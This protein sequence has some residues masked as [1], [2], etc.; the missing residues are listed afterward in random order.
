MKTK[1]LARLLRSDK[2]IPA[3]VRIEA[4]QRLEYLQHELDSLKDR[5]L[6]LKKQVKEKQ[7]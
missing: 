7:E 4:A 1:S 3:L 2:E 6:S 5:N